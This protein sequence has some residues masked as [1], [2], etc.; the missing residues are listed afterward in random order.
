MLAYGS[1]AFTLFNPTQNFTEALL[2]ATGTGKDKA[3]LIAMIM[4][5]ITS[6]L[7]M[8]V[9][10]KA[11][12]SAANGAKDIGAIKS[13]KDFLGPKALNTLINALRLL[14]A[15]ANVTS[16]AFKIQQYKST[17]DLAALQEAVGAINSHLMIEKTSSQMEYDL[18]NQGSEQYNKEMQTIEQMIANESKIL[19]GYD[20]MARA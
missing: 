13:V 6:V 2:E 15:G 4:G 8:A 12:T 14:R 18:S 20:A 7:A 11:G 9:G 1:Q 5:I 16:N 10:M 19:A 17:N 3:K